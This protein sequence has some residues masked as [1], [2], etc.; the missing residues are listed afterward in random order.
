MVRTTPMFGGLFPR[1]EP[2]LAVTRPSGQYPV[3]QAQFVLNP[4]VEIQW[5][6]QTARVQPG[7]VTSGKGMVGPDGTVVLGPYGICKVGGLS[8]DKATTA[9]EQHLADYMKAPA[10]RL[11]ALVPSSQP[12]STG[13][14]DLAWRSAPIGSTQTIIE[15]P[16]ASAVQPV[17]WARAGR[18]VEQPR[19]VV[20]EPEQHFGDGSFLRRVFDRLGLT[21]R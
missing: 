18:V 9:V 7:Q 4:G 5:Q 10:V 13:R 11:S 1:Q 19:T 16:G 8:L 3:A 14:A 6:A 17:S 15:K 20:V 12:M 2:V 21:Q